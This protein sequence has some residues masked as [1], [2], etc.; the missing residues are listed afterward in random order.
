MT[1]A[2]SRSLVT[3]PATTDHPPL[4]QCSCAPCCFFCLGEHSCCGPIALTAWLQR[5]VQYLLGIS[6]HPDS[7]QAG[8]S[9]AGWTSRSSFLHHVRELP[10]PR[11]KLTCWE[12]NMRSC[13]TPQSSPLPSTKLRTVTL[14]SRRTISFPAC[15]ACTAC[16]APAA[17][18]MC[19]WWINP[20]YPPP[21]PAALTLHQQR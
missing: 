18:L 7:N 21:I 9:L 13:L 16:A 1:N 4:L 14:P 10:V 11:L 6:R 19:Q 15:K 12:P 8:L 20:P 5:L 17:T 2:L 3:I